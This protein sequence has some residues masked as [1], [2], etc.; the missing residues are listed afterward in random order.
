MRRLAHNAPA[1]FD[2]FDTP[3]PRLR[4]AYLPTAPPAL[5][6]AQRLVAARRTR[7]C[8]A[9]GTATTAWLNASASTAQHVVPSRAG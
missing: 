7:R 2:L 3:A 8:V 1:L 5:A 4:T 6:D 9:A